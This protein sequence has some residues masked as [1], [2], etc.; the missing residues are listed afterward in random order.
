MKRAENLQ[1]ISSCLLVSCDVS[2]LIHWMAAGLIQRIYLVQI[3]HI[4]VQ[5]CYDFLLQREKWTGREGNRATD[6]VLKKGGERNSQQE[7]TNQDTFLFV[8]VYYLLEMTQLTA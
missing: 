2:G 7:K 4:P 3:F 5:W 6:G 8:R 1:V